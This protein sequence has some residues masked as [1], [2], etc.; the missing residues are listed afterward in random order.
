MF[1]DSNQLNELERVAAETAA[2]FDLSKP[3]LL[4]A[5]WFHFGHGRPARLLIVIHHLVVDGISW[6]ILMEDLE[7]CYHQ[8]D[9]VNQLPAKTDSLKRWA[10]KPLGILQVQ[11][12]AG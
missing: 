5:V 1:P 6:R 11:A 8:S 12:P 10:E 3:P 2:S 7:A 4:R 9:S